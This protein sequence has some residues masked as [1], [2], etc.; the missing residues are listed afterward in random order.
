M[1]E[2]MSIQR[3]VSFALPSLASLEENDDR[4]LSA[5]L[6]IARLRA[7]VAV[8]R[9]LTDHVEHLADVAAVEGVQAQVVE[10][11]ARLGCRL[12]EVA[13]SLAASDRPEASGVFRHLDPLLSD[14]SR[15]PALL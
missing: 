6:T 12:L 3:P 1:P 11:I 4:R 2:T 13:A 9:T 5:E 14:D 10:E 7:Q 8:V 15:G